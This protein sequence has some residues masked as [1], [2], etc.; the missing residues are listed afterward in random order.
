[1]LRSNSQ[2]QHMKQ[3]ITITLAL[4]LLA[5][6]AFAGGTGTG[7]T[8]I[9]DGNDTVTIVLNNDSPEII[10]NP[11]GQTS[12]DLAP[13]NISGTAQF[14]YDDGNG[15]GGNDTWAWPNVSQGGTIE[16][17]GLGTPPTYNG[18]EFTVPEPPS[19]LIAS[20]IAA[21]LLV[22]RHWQISGCPSMRASGS[23]SQSA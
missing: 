18:T 21:G 23:R 19:F 17:S 7:L 8:F 14:S 13:W 20:L 15:G 22:G 9:N 3:Q 16:F 2:C 5:T 4:T 11:N 6:C 10:V 12:T 1:M